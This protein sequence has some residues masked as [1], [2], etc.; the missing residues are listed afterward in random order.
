[1]SVT[2][3]DYYETLGVARSS[4][5][6]EITKAY[7][8]LARKYHP[9]LNKEP[10]AEDKFKQLNEAHEVLKDEENRKKYDA[11][12]QNWK[13]GQNFSPPPG[14]DDIFAQFGG[15]QGQGPRVR[16]GARGA[17]AGQNG[18]AGFSDFFNSI[19]GDSGGAARGGFGGGMGARP[20]AGPSHEAELT[21]TLRDVY[22]RETKTISFEV[23]EQTE[24]GVPERK[25]KSY[26]VKIPAGITDGKV[27]RLAG[28][29]GQGMAGG[30]AG[31]LLLKIR[32]AKDLKFRA[33]GQRL[34]STLRISPSE[35]ALGAKVRVPTLD[36][37]VTMNIPP[38]TPSG[39]QLRVKGKGLPKKNGTH[40][41]LIVETSIVVPT[42][43]SEQE[44]KAYELL[45]E[46]SDFRPREE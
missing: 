16:P 14:W 29:G 35:A 10:E 21:V 8:S 30:A 25:V 3:Q 1:M 5:P 22:K 32:F 23:N 2:F 20:Q 42:K 41:N 36:G 11:L 9:D 18:G 19:F 4:S 12:G 27:I 45:Q 7:R 43:L 31:D 28:Q 33:E 39:K 34:F 13:N 44:Q 6:E 37:A 38:G 40:D 15:A 24:S 46:V 17:G 26:Q